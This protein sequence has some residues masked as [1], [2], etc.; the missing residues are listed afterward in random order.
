MKQYQI[1]LLLFYFSKVS[2]Y[3]Y[4]TDTITVDPCADYW[5]LSY[6]HPYLEQADSLWGFEKFDRAVVFLS[7]SSHKI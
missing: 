6:K 4:V 3:G 5:E 1:I 7:T 2:G